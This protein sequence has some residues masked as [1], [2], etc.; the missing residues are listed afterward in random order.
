MEIVLQIKPK[1]QYDKPRY[2]KKITYKHQKKKNIKINMGNCN[3]LKKSPITTNTNTNIENIY[4]NAIT[5][6]QKHFRLFQFRKNQKQILQSNIIEKLQTP[7]TK[8]S[9]ISHLNF[10]KMNN[11]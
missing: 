5:L 2:K 6:V 1:I 8:F 3:S 11:E 7:Y 9:T 10:K 4:L